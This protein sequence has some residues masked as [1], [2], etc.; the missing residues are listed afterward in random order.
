MANT[1]IFT[2][3][4]FLGRA[5]LGTA[6]LAGTAC[7]FSGG[8]PRAADRESDPAGAFP[9]AGSWTQISEHLAVYHGPIHVGV[10][11]NPQNGKALLIDCTDQG[12]V[13]EKLGTTTVDRILLTHYHRDQACGAAA[14]QQRGA[15]IAVPA[16]ERA[17]FE[18]VA[19]YWSDPKR[20]WH[21]Y[22]YHPHHL[23]PTQPLRVDEAYADGQTF[24][25]GPARIGVIATPGHTDGSA[26]YLVEV[27]GRR[28][29]FCGDCIFDHGQIWEL[30]SL[31]KG[32]ARKNCRISD[33]HGFLGSHWQLVE[34]LGN[35]RRNQPELLVP[36]HGRLMRDPAGAIEALVARLAACYDKYVA[37][38]A[39][40][41]YY[42]ELFAEFTSRKDH[43][44][45]R[46][47]KPA[48]SCLRHFGTTWTLVSRDKAALVMDCGSP[49]V[50]QKL[51]AMRQ[52]KEIESVEGLWVTHYH[53]DHVDG[54]AEFQKAF[55]CPCIADR[56]V[57]EV[58]SDPPA[59]RLPCISPT[60]ARVDRATQDGESWPWHEF[61]L[62]A[63]HFPGQTLYHGALLVEGDGLRMLFVGDSHTAAGIDD[64]C[65]QNRNWLGKGVG[66]DRCLALLDRLRPTHIFNCH[67]NDAFDFTSEECR[68]MRE[69]LVQRERLF[70]QLFPWDHSNF[71]MDGSWVRCHPFQQSATPGARLSF[72]VFVTNHACQSRKAQCRT[73]FDRGPVSLAG[74]WT[75]AEIPAK[76]EQP[77]PLSF[78]VPHDLAPGRHVVSIDI[79]WDKWNLPRFAELVLV[80]G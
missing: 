28:V 42:P 2:R 63:Y 61:K 12:D 79:R 51:Q 80:V 26:S 36:S 41:H 1:P 54:I 65:A 24:D 46:P 43:M 47:G 5:G 66:F 49:Q 14:L 50:V 18:K 20:R 37:I 77:I 17:R 60:R 48:P 52:A 11:R 59:W 73:I 25:W 39:L 29:V 69:N 19:E 67:V 75:A 62:T 64:Y 30:Y 6:G 34:S 31:Q 15:K 70:G 33:Y 55:D 56:H 57:A 16:A 32:F 71:G 22:D 7:L 27:D 13:L 9:Q 23:V 58:I 8:E 38:S 21:L 78:T 76:T 74:Q 40:R 53:D 68:F 3:R 4:D 35:I 72:Q 10:L 44:A 45:I